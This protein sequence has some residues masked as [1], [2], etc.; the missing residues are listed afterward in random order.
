M[1]RGVV[2]WADRKCVGALLNVFYERLETLDSV[3]ELTND[4]IEFRDEFVLVGDA[5]FQID[6]T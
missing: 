6:D 1:R 3:R 5:N 4:F 2:R